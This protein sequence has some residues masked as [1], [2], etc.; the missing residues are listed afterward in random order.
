MQFPEFLWP[1]RFCALQTGSLSNRKSND[2]CY[3]WTIAAALH[4]SKHLPWEWS[5]LHLIY[6][7]GNVR[8]RCLLPGLQK[9]KVAFHGCFHRGISWPRPHKKPLTAVNQSHEE[10]VMSVMADGSKK[11]FLIYRQLLPHSEPRWSLG[12]TRNQRDSCP[13]EGSRRTGTASVSAKS[14]TVL[15]V[16]LTFAREFKEKKKNEYFSLLRSNNTQ[17][18][19]YLRFVASSHLCAV[20]VK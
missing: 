6:I 15:M 19:V 8:T 3:C 9:T 13:D 10:P 1:F 17:L 11:R 20:C 18:L 2:G 16:V 14:K 4:S 12:A 5:L 7:A